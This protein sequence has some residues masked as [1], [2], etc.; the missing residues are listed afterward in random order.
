[1]AI[2]EH[3][4]SGGDD[5]AGRLSENDDRVTPKNAVDRHQDSAGEREPPETDRNV[6]HSATLR[7]NPLD[8]ETSREER[9]RDEAER[10]EQV[11][12]PGGG[13][14]MAHRCECSCGGIEN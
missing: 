8:D 10:G 5:Q 2:D 3:Q 13:I 6:R 1:M 7:C 12:V 9:L 11:P 14:E 4:V